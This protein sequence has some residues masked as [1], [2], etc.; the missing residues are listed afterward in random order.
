MSQDTFYVICHNIRSR[1]NVGSVFRTA[2]AF[3]VARIYLTGYTPTPPH[4]KISKT[5]LGAQNWIPWEKKRSIGRL[6]KALADKKIAIAA[7]EQSSRSKTIRKFKPRF[8]LALIVGNEV[9][10]LPRNVIRKT[11]T[12]IEIPMLG[13]KESLNV[14]VAFGIAAYHMRFEKTP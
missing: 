12:I 8:P 1:E 3:A 13:R 4:E 2:D 7:L 11:G 6:L 10:G 5:A 14:A 9:K